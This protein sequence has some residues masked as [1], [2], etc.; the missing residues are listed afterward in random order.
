[1]LPLGFARSGGYGRLCVGVKGQFQAGGYGAAEGVVATGKAAEN[2]QFSRHRGRGHGGP[3]DKGEG[4]SQGL[5]FRSE[6]FLPL[7]PE[8]HGLAEQP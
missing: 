6:Y 3:Q 8:P 4:L 5:G 1:M 2:Y 7:E